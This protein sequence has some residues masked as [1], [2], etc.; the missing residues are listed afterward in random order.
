MSNFYEKNIVEIKQEY[1][2]FLSDV[3][4]PL[5]YEGLS[6]MYKDSILM[7][8]EYID[9]SKID[10]RVEVPGVLMIFQMC[11]RDVPNHNKNRIDSEMDRIKTASKCS[12]FFDDLVKAVIKSYILLL[13]FSSS[14]KKCKVLEDR[15]YESISSSNFIHKCYIET[16]SCF[17]NNPELFWHKASPM[18]IKRNQIMTIDIIKDSIKSAI[19]KMLPMKLVLEEFLKNEYLEEDAD[20]NVYIPNNR[21][22]NMQGMVNKDLYG[23]D[24]DNTSEN[25]FE[26]MNDT[27]GMTA[28]EYMENVQDKIREL[29]ESVERNVGD[30]KENANVL[31]V[32]NGE[33]KEEQKGEE[34]NNLV[35]QSIA[36]VNTKID[37][38]KHYITE[39]SKLKH[40]KLSLADILKKELGDENINLKPEIKIHP[41]LETI[42]EITKPEF[43]LKNADTDTDAE[44][45]NINK[46]VENSES[47]SASDNS[48]KNSDEK[49][50]VIHDDTDRSKFFADY[51]DE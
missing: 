7:N 5:I 8:K 33:D 3:L 34:I 39:P 10:A 27:E 13:T 31:A 23:R 49:E 41:T 42:K 37:E 16:A 29:K 22:K 19:R 1:T 24:H 28:S 25:G 48:R 17:Y 46:F 50:K 2:T 9:K 12:E 4:A 45:D 44:N 32:N 26:E 47:R 15:F 6:S 43:K 21:Y 38:N 36:D 11:L 14:K 20:V 35:N 51:L 40:K 18:E 30:N